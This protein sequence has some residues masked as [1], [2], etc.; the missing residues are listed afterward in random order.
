M[1]SLTRVICLF[2]VLFT[3]SGCGSRTDLRKIEEKEWA[4]TFEVW[5]P[6]FKPAESINVITWNDYIPKDIFTEFTK[7][8]GTKVNVTYISS[9]EEMYDLVKYN[10]GK[11]DLIMP[12]DYMLVKMINEKM[13]SRLNHDNVPNIAYLDEQIRRIE[14]DFGLKHSVPLFY[15]SIG[16]AFNI[17]YIHGFP[18]TWDFVTQHLKNEYTNTRVSIRKDVRI[19]MGVALMSMGYSPNSTNPKEITEAKDALINAIKTT[20]LMLVG[21][22]VD[23]LLKDQDLLLSVVWNGTASA[24]LHKNNNIHF[25]YPEG[26]AIATYESGAVPAGS[27]NRETGELF[28]N[29]LLTAQVL[30]RAS[31]FN[32]YSNSNPNSVQ[33]IDLAVRQGPGYIMPHEDMRVYIEDVGDQLQLYTDAWKEILAAEPDE[34]VV[35]LPLPKNGLFHNTHGSTTTAKQLKE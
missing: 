25:I 12:S 20:G 28:L 26:P 19:A 13:L 10:P 9:N 21:D 24:A 2:L 7:A 14:H 17:M 1:N 16:I 8:Y 30:G 11:Y 18:R 35:S 4:S 29:Y 5:K 22:N 27:K 31:N 15:S 33:Y 6:G 32:N 23:S 34:D 3:I